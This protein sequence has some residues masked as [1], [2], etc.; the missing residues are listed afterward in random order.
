MTFD[1]FLKPAARCCLAPLSVWVLVGCT[2]TTPQ[3]DARFGEAVRH[4]LQAQALAPA[5]G[6][7]GPAAAALDASTA[8]AAVQ[9]YRD[10]FKTPPPVVNVINLGTGSGP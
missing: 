2:S 3:Y 7:D 1:S 5:A 4:N 8:R 9:R 10:S 6:Q